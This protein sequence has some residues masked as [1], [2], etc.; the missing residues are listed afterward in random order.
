MSM[1]MEYFSIIV[2]TLQAITGVPYQES[3]R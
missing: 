3:L 2:T 1:V